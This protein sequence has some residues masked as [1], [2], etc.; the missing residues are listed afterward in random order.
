MYK[1]LDKYTYLKFTFYTV[2]SNQIVLNKIP[3]YDN[4]CNGALG[5]LIVWI[6]FKGIH[7]LKFNV[8]P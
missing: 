4:E 6:F 1:N 2:Y 3:Q 8:R 7:P 5:A